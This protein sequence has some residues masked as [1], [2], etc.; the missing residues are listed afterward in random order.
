MAERSDRVTDLFRRW[1]YR[2][3]HGMANKP[4]FSR[5]GCYGLLSRSGGRL[6]DR[7]PSNVG[8]SVELNLDAGVTEGCHFLDPNLRDH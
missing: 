8:I 4:I 2:R 7:S 6:G 1:C 5:R 3:Q